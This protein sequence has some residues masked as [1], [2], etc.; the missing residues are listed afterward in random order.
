MDNTL[1]N[2][3]PFPTPEA[4]SLALVNFGRKE[5]MFSWSSVAPDCP[6]IHYN[7]LASNCGSCPTTT[8]HTN[9]TCTDLPSDDSMCNF[10]IQTVICGNI[11]GKWSKPLTFNITETLNKMTS[12]K[13]GV[14]RTSRET[15][16]AIII[17]LLS[18]CITADTVSISIVTV[19]VS[20]LLVTVMI[21]I[22]A[23]YQLHKRNATLKASSR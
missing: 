3:V 21:V 6:S 5:I 13:K 17:L 10:A 2:T 9:A 16:N 15:T 11:T 22:L 8:N 23:C 14:F 18:L 1:S 4:I 19:G 7:I 12:S 20:A